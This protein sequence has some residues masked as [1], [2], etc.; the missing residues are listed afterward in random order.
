MR[1]GWQSEGEADRVR[2]GGWQGER[3]RLAER[4]GG[5]GRVIGGCWQSVGKADRVR[6]RLAE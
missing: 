4:E 3:G 1:V 6:G 2:R 5:A